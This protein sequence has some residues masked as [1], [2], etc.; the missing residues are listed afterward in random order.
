MLRFIIIKSPCEREFERLVNDALDE[1]YVSDG[2][3]VNFNDYLVKP[4]VLDPTYPYQYFFA[5]TTNSIIEIK[6]DMSFWRE[7][8]MKHAENIEECYV[9]QEVNNLNKA[10]AF[11]YPAE[12]TGWIAVSKNQQHTRD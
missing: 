4:M 12:E 8:A 10:T 11:C 9:I 6:S 7:D 2:P 1:G 5:D 3:L